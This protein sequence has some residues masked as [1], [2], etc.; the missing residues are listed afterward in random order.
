MT[1]DPG[2]DFTSAEPTRPPD[3][4]MRRTGRKTEIPGNEIPNA[5]AHERPEDHVIVHDGDINDPFP[6]GHRDTVPEEKERDKI[7]KSRPDHGILRG[8]DAGRDHR[9]DRIRG[10]VKTVQEIKEKRQKNKENNIEG[11]ALP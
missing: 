11:H 6:H 10:I 4:G 9:R 8:K 7:E 1:R 2:P 3:Q 5:G